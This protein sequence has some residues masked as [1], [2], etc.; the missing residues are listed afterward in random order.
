MSNITANEREWMSRR[1]CVWC[2]QKLSAKHCGV[3]FGERCDIDSKRA[4]A[5]ADY[6]LRA[7]RSS[8]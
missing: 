6:E 8:S 2:G 5:L 4:L 1:E 7:R 3:I